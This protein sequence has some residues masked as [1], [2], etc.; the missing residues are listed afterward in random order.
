LGTEVV[1]LHTQEEVIRKRKAAE[2]VEAQLAASEAELRGTM[3]SR[4]L[5]LEPPVQEMAAD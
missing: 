5:Q 3:A 4:P 1:S 2:D